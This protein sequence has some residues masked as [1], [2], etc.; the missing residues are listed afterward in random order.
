MC[1]VVCS[2]K[3]TFDYHICVA[4]LFNSISIISSLLLDTRVLL[5]ILI[6]FVQSIQ[7]YTIFSFFSFRFYVPINVFE[8]SFAFIYLLKII[9]NLI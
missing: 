2:S 7:F 1:I 4:I 5:H 8:L 9:Y 3:T 6:R